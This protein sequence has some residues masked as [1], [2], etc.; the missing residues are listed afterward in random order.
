MNTLGLSHVDG[1]GSAT[2]KARYC[3]AESPFK[4]L[5]QHRKTASLN[6]LTVRFLTESLLV[7]RRRIF[8]ATT[9]APPFSRT[10]TSNPFAV[11]RP[12]VSLNSAGR[13][14][15]RIAVVMAG[16]R[17]S[18]A[19]IVS[20]SP[21]HCCPSRRC[22]TPPSRANEPPFSRGWNTRRLADSRTPQP[23][24]VRRWREMCIA[25][26]T[27]PAPARRPIST[28]LSARAACVCIGPLGPELA[29]WRGAAR[30]RRDGG[31]VSTP[32]GLDGERRRADAREGTAPISIASMAR[33]DRVAARRNMRVA[34][35]RL[36]IA[37]GWVIVN[38]RRVLLNGCL[39]GECRD[40]SGTPCPAR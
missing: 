12:T 18:S 14:R 5:N 38:S 34:A 9:L 25:G 28:Q 35:Q 27:N 1:L 10:P 26:A 37:Q 36:S 11:S 20:A 7:A 29:R 6:C 3:K 16:K 32:T 21:S 8:V 13:E 30:W 2:A 15:A 24:A 31:D 19:K 23:G 4:S 40:G 22:R 17:R 33:P 39:P